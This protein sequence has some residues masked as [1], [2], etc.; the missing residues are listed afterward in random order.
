MV[1]RAPA[2]LTAQNLLLPLLEVTIFVSLDVLVTGM[3]QPS[4]RLTP[5]GMEKGV[6][7]LKQSAVQLLVCH[8]S[9]R[10]LMLPPLTT[11]R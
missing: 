7:L 4:M 1:P 8:G 5:C 11:L 2:L 10:S 6:V 9:T 3:A